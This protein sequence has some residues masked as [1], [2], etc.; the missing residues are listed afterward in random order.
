MLVLVGLTVFGLGRGAYDANNMPVVC[1]LVP[2]EL[3]ATAYGFLNCVGTLVGGT[4][5][6]AA[7]S[8]KAAFG[9]SVMLQLAGALMLIGALI[10]WRLR[11]P[12]VN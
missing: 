10:L 12:A 7:G 1:Q 11:P 9:L 5:A 6:F 3:R 8:L 4:V 2:T